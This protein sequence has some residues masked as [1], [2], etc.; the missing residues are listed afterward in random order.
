[1]SDSTL[2]YT[3]PKPIANN[4][5]HL[6]ICI[7]GAGVSGICSAKNLLEY[8]FNNITIFEQHDAIGGIWYYNENPNFPNAMYP[9]LHTNFPITYM[10]F[11]DFF[12][13]KNTLLY[14]PYTVVYKYMQQYIKH[15]NINKHIKLNHKIIQIK[16]PS[17]KSNKWIVKYTNDK[18]II[19]VSVFDFVLVCNGHFR[20]CRFPKYIKDI[21]IPYIHSRSY[22]GPNK[23]FYK[24]KNILLI[25]SGNTASDIVQDLV[26]NK[27]C[28]K[29][30]HSTSRIQFQKRFNS[31]KLQK[32]ENYYMLKPGIKC[33]DSIKKHFIFEDN[34][35][36]KDINFVIFATGYDYHFEFIDFKKYN[37]LYYLY[38]H[39]FCAYYP[40]LVY[41]SLPVNGLTWV[42]AH[43][44]AIW[45]AKILCEMR[46]IG[47]G[48]NME[49]I[50]K[51]LVSKKEMI[52]E[53]S[54][55]D[56]DHIFGVVGG[57]LFRYLD[58][59]C[60]NANIKSPA[61]EMRLVLKDGLTKR[62][63]ELVMQRIFTPEP[64]IDIFNVVTKKKKASCDSV[65]HLLELMK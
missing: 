56:K 12:Y 55:K 50:S 17:D 20:Y 62:G 54:N 19:C 22:R 3:N 36:L 63:P 16:P 47:K 41:M 11:P 57:E 8:G 43:F 2:V 25:G 7:I 33:F 40:S 45:L 59:I 14:P 13:P 65:D 10:K 53:C 9:T 44:Q 31:S 49:I 42:S 64:V 34:S 23:S 5:K 39:M 51:Y 61:N 15:F 32:Y 28:R 1:M 27:I 37:K 29:I 52:R 24:N 48:D 4:N 58:V 30:Y 26:P 38:N 60:R 21:S 6:Q 18:N 46:M 35:V